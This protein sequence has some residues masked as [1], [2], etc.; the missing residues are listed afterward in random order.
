MRAVSQRWRE[1]V[2][3]VTR[4]Q[5]VVEWSNDGGRTWWPTRY[6]GGGQVTAAATSQIRWSC[7]VTIDGAGLG[8]NGINPY[9]TR[10]RILHG[11][12]GEPLLPM[13][14]YKV[15]DAGWS[16]DYD[17]AIKIAGSSYEVYVQRA[18]F[19]RPRTIQPGPARRVLEDLIREVL[20]DAQISWRG[21]DPGLQVGRIE[22]PRDRW[23]IIDGSSSSTSIARALGARVYAGPAGEWIVAPVPTLEDRPVWEAAEGV[24]GVLLTHGEELTDES[25][26]NVVVVN[27]VS[28]DGETPPFAPGIAADQDPL[29]LTYIGRSPDEGGFG[30]CPRFYASPLIRSTVQA[31]QA[32]Q[33]MLAPYLGLKQ[34]V[35]FTQLHDPSIEPGD[36]GIVHTRKGPRRVIPDSITYS[37]D[38]APMTFE[39]RT[40]ATRLAGGQIDAPSGSGD[41]EDQ[42]A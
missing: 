4:W 8:R 38:G 14:R 12:A 35:S 34:Q 17:Q 27:G 6:L 7:D 21:I 32:A 11:M 13:G 42:A 41:E 25:V 33:G 23:G 24:G 9:T 16:S 15:T 10:L 19:L 2:A 31:Q 26:Y 36:V 28:D 22:E 30:E 20:P 39:T 18:R 5:T 29:S 3:G 1:M 40:T 37:L